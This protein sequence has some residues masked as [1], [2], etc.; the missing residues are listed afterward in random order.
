MLF[1]DAVALTDTRFTKDGGYMVVD[2]AIARTGIQDYNGYELG[3]PDLGVVKVYRP[4]AEVFSDRAMASFAHK[5]VTDDHPSEMVSAG[6]WKQH[7]V[8][9]TGDTVVRDGDHLR[10]PFTLMDAAAIRTVQDGKRELS[11]GYMADI[12]WT[13]GKT[14]DGQLFDAS[15]K[16][17]TGNHLAIVSR[18][19][20]GATCRIG[21]SWGTSQQ[22]KPT[23]ADTNRAVL[24][25]GVSY[26]LTDQ[27]AQLVEKLT[28]DLA[29]AVSKVTGKE[30][31]I[32]A[33]SSTHAGA[34]AAKDGEIA[35][36]TQAH[37]GV[38]A[39][40]DAE[41]ATLRSLTDAAALD[42]QIEARSAVVAATRRVLGDSYDP[43]G[44]SVADM[45]TAVVTKRLGDAAVAGRPPEFFAAAFDT[46]TLA[47][48]GTS[49]V[50]PLRNVVRDG[51]T[52]PTK[53]VDTSKSYQDRM[54][55]RFKGAK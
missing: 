12:D 14:P 3:R 10:V 39:A 22:E 28:R 20:A 4:E 5:P 33:L 8:G 29:D 42:S 26:Q 43:K 27:G 25:D 16:S 21:D 50:D 51:I 36:L 37:A 45:Q 2:A 24:V 23:M 15:L 7:A 13:A 32:A 53:V 44:K 49:Q 11:A 47:D 31:Q 1:T 40:K 9:M 41:I 55:N 30:G 6:N 52:D 18:G 48:A 54:A 17:I 34:I 19:R 46:L 38:I 35:A